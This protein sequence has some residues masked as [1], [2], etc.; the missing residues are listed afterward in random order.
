MNKAYAHSKTTKIAW[1]KD[2][3]MRKYLNLHMYKS[4]DNE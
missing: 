4:M 3:R 1:D 2:Y